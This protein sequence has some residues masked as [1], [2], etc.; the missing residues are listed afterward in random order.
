MLALF[1]KVPRIQHPKLLKID[2]VDYPTF[3]AP[4]PGN[5]REYPHKTYCEKQSHWATSLLLIV[6]IY[7]HS[8]FPCRLR[9][10][11]VLCIGVLYGRSRSSRFFYVVKYQFVFMDLQNLYGLAKFSHLFIIIV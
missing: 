10:M 5:S 7:L 1:P 6:R 11:H 4:S 2:V 9:K 8:N 3:D